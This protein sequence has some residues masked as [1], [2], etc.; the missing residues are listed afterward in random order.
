MTAPE[1]VPDQG[2]DSK[3]STEAALFAEGE[4]LEREGARRDH[5]RQQAFRDHVNVAVIALFW[6]VAACVGAG[7]LVYAWHLLTPVCW[8]F[9]TEAALSKLETILVAAVLSSALTNYANRQMA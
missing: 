5:N 8:H 1:F 2:V 6:A 4:D 9:A 3:A 7:V